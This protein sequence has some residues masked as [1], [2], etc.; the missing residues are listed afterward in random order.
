MRYHPTPQSIIGI[1]YDGWQLFKATFLRLWP[2][3][4]LLTVL[5]FWFQWSFLIYAHGSAWHA[6]TTT[7]SVVPAGAS[8][9]GKAWVRLKASPLMQIQTLNAFCTAL[10]IY[11]MTAMSWAAMDLYMTEGRVI[12]GQVWGVLKT[13]WWVLLMQSL[14]LSLVVWLGVTL[15]VLPAVVCYVLFYFARFFVCI[16]GL[17]VFA[18]MKESAQMVWGTGWWRTF[19]LLLWIVLCMVAWFAFTLYLHRHVVWFQQPAHLCLY[20]VGA[21]WVSAALE[22]LYGAWQLIMFHD[23]RLRWVI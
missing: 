18:S 2:I 3:W 12:W 9:L 11:M 13:R 4:G 7:P 21:A 6:S 22:L 23:L 15:L 8:E 14:L 17:G 1:L 19:F 10:W 5:Y 20:F 16:N